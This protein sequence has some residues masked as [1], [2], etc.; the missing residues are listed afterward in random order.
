MKI[1]RV[2]ILG[3]GF[4]GKYIYKQLVKSSPSILPYLIPRS[5]MD[6]HCESTLTKFILN[7]DIQYVVNCSGFTGRP[8]ID[9]AETKKEECWY[10]NTVLPLRISNVCKKLDK[11]FIQIS[12]GCIYTGY[13]KHFTE[14][15]TPN[16][17]LYDVSSFY[18]KSK[19]A[20]ETLNN[21]GCTIR[22]RMPFVGELV[23]RNYITKLL[24]YDNIIDYR[25]SKTS[26]L[27]LARFV[28]HIITSNTN[29][30]KIGCINFVNP[31][32][33]NTQEFIYTLKQ[34]NIENPKWK[35]VPI[36][37]ID[38]KAP[39]SNCV[40]SIDKLNSM[41]PDF[42]LPTEATALRNVLSE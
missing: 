37:E 28:E 17:G 20:F 33:M 11:E 32:A 38:I 22:I 25:N 36:D 1:S 42:M 19:H 26:I 3:G 15:D 12:S 2:L 10:L 41:F 27:D 16:F 23:D 29:T 31:D 35:I 24:K 21:Y 9:E 7:N 8:N 5:V 14:D 30:S 4:V 6:Y 34:F 40:L 13:E 39:R 18:S